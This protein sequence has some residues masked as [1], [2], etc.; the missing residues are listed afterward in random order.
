MAA[1][2]A[3]WGDG[4]MHFKTKKIHRLSD[5]SLIGMYGSWPS[6]LKLLQF[7]NSDDEGLPRFKEA[8]AILIR[9]RTRM[10]IYESG[11]LMPIQS[12]PYV[13]GGTGSTVALGAM[14]AGASAIEAIQAAI[15]HDSHTRGPVRSLKLE[16]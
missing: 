14:H 12:A 16:E 15:A 11:V 2:S 3:L 7:L 8:G 5:G 10:F 4:T 9:S 6:C 13:A 1:D